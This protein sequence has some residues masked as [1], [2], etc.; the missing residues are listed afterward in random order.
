MTRAIRGRQ[1]VLTRKV[2][3]LLKFV[4]TSRDKTQPETRSSTS[5]PFVRLTTIT[6][7]KAA[8]QEKIKAVED[9]RNTF[10]AFIDELTEHEQDT[11][12][13][14]VNE[15]VRK[16]NEA[17]AD[18]DD[19]VGELE[20]EELALKVAVEVAKNAAERNAIMNGTVANQ[21][22]LADLSSSFAA[23]GDSSPVPVFAGEPVDWPYWITLYNEAVH[24]QQMSNLG[25]FNKLLKVVKGPAL[26]TVR[27]FVVKDANYQLAYEA[28][29]RRYGDVTKLTMELH[30]KLDEVRPPSNTVQDQRRYSDE[31][32]SI[33]SQ[34][35][36]LTAHT[37]GIHL[38]QSILKKLPLKTSR[39]VIQK[40]SLGDM[41][42]CSKVLEV[43][44]KVL[45]D[46][47]RDQW[48]LAMISDDLGNQQEERRD[49]R[50]RNPVGRRYE[51][52]SP[53]SRDPR[54][55]LSGRNC[56]YC[57]QAGHSCWN[58]SECPT[59]GSREAV[60]RRE[61][62]CFN[63][64]EQGHM[65]GAC[66]K[67]GCRLCN[68]K[69]HSSICNQGI[70]SVGRPLAGQGSA[71][72]IPRRPADQTATGANQE[73][74]QRSLCTSVKQSNDT[75]GTIKV[76]RILTATVK[77]FNEDRKMFEELGVVLDTGSQISTVAESAVQRL[78]LK[79]KFEH[80]TTVQGL[81]EVEIARKKVG[82]FDL[83]LLDAMGNRFNIEAACISK[84]IVK[85]AVMEILDDKDRDLLQAKGIKPEGLHSGTTKQPEVLIGMDQLTDVFTGGELVPLPPDRMVLPTRF[86]PILIGSKT[87]RKADKKGINANVNCMSIEDTQSADLERL[88]TME[89]G[90]DEYH[91]P[92]KTER[93][94]V[95]D[96]VVQQFEKDIRFTE[97]GYV[98]RLPWKAD[99]TKESL[100]DNRRIAFR[101]LQ[102]SLMQLRGEMSRKG[103]GRV[104]ERRRQDAV[105]ERDEPGSPRGR[106]RSRDQSERHSPAS[107]RHR[108]PS[109]RREKAVC[110]AKNGSLPGGAGSIAKRGD[111][112]EPG[113]RKDNSSSSSSSSCSSCSSCS[114]S[115]SSE[116]A[117]SDSESGS[118]NE[119]SNGARAR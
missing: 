40:L 19:Y 6:E 103:A 118:G 55:A 35:N 110:P 61:S 37:D 13:E 109:S 2:N 63:C 74:L 8:V 29:E 7:N 62:R 85:E 44:E 17:I 56:V 41:E 97:E 66:D 69:H 16:L 79:K 112:I 64:L 82:V 104:Q 83:N 100:P 12:K 33:H 89:A 68:R 105:G 48:G 67:S 99:G 23:M 86:G 116:R 111:T 3:A 25:K 119:D 51:R 49:F 73:P 90:T 93:K 31:I 24:N 80:F 18:A 15:S 39:H 115:G 87:S 57:K 1:A 92:C 10:D 4:S 20:A 113:A 60:L 21:S 22:S 5:E 52:E 11:A 108:A 81:N 77:V 91:G 58:C 59:K 38:T 26:S 42:K 102:G 36:T 32:G 27:R 34:L 43:L 30:R 101:R 46:M 71:N 76:G 106:K 88:W 28:L 75:T 117:E 98:I 72:R 14:S 78:G 65:L 84:I 70:N 96:R 47:E 107:K 45:D 95:N 54:P 53:F 114:S 9:E 94:A 50:S